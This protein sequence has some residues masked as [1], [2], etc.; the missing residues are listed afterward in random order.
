MGRVAVDAHD[1]ARLVRG[2]FSRVSP[3]GRL[4]S[5]PELVRLP[6]GEILAPGREIF[7]PTRTNA[8]AAATTVQVFAWHRTNHA[9]VHVYDADGTY[10]LQRE[11]GD[12]THPAYL[13]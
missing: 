1:R 9:D 7:Q 4:V 2:V 12:L 10:T 6:D 13:Q 3:D 11:L 5:L 8:A